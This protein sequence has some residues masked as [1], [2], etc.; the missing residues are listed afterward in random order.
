MSRHKSPRPLSELTREELIAE[1]ET[2]RA[3]LASAVREIVTLRGQLARKIEDVGFW[4]LQY[5]RAQKVIQDTVLTMDKV[6][7]QHPP[8]EDARNMFASLTGKKPRG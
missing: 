4:Q 1:V 8:S 7:N 2:A 3:S 5:M 6:L